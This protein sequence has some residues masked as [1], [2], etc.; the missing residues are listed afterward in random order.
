MFSALTHLKRK[1]W[2]ACHWM[3]KVTAE[4]ME[5]QLGWTFTGKQLLFQK[6][7][8]GEKNKI[9][10]NTR[11]KRCAKTDGK[12]LLLFISSIFIF[13]V[14]TETTLCGNTLS[15][16]VYLLHPPHF[17]IHVSHCDNIRCRI[18][19]KAVQIIWFVRSSSHLQKGRDR[20]K[21]EGG[22]GQSHSIFMSKTLQYTG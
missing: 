22:R 7:Q 3:N 13:L 17:A 9:N 14:S 5:H 16:R 19:P 15:R 8:S 12:P 4:L 18:K 11:I 1:G 6:C 20:V 10:L 2:L 21:R